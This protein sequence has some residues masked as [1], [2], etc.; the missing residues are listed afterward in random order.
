MIARIHRKISHPAA[1]SNMPKIK[2]LPYHD[3]VVVFPRA[4]CLES[5]PFVT[6][7]DRILLL[8]FAASGEVVVMA[9]CASHFWH[10]PSDWA[11]R[12]LILIKPP[13]P[14]SR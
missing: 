11:G 10:Y 9:K 6:S 4:C 2:R 12:S 3:T 7:G 14:E 13:T 1:T 5:I 8:C